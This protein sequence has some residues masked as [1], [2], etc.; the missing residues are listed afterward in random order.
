MKVVSGLH[1]PFRPFLRPFRLFCMRAA[2]EFVRLE[3]LG[4]GR[5]TR[6]EEGAWSRTLSMEQSGRGAGFNMDTVPAS[7]GAGHSRSSTHF[8][9]YGQAV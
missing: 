1:W 8:T 3:R 7:L 9:V 6:R 2:R 5:V 4:L